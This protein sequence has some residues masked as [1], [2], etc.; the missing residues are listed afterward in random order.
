MD[1]S[2]RVLGKLLGVTDQAIA[3]WE[4]ARQKPVT[5]KAAERLLR[6][7]YSNTIGGSGE[8]ATILDQIAK[9]DAEVAEIELHLEKSAEGG[10]AK[11]SRRAR[12]P[13]ARRITARSISP[14]AH[15]ARAPRSTSTC[16]RPIPL[17]HLRVGDAARSRSKSSTCR[18]PSP[19]RRWSLR[20]FA[21]SPR[22]A[23]GR[24][25]RAEPVC[26]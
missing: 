15:A 6:V 18:P 10:W 12:A 19:T 5:N 11:A 1:L 17:G 8:F 7:C 2:Q 22:P 13:A 4:K 20:C 26:D 3:K 14:A 9:L 23:P 21:A 16:P 24:Q 25:P